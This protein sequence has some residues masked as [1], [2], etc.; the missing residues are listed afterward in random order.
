MLMNKTKQ[1]LYEAAK[2]LFAEFGYSGL[3]MRQL[4]AEAGV[5]LSVTYH[6]YQD[7]DELLRQIFEHTSRQLGVLRRKLPRH[8]TTRDMLRDRVAFQLDH[9]QDVVF[10]LKYYMHYRNRYAH[11]DNGYLPATAYRHIEEVLQFGYD[12]REIQL[13]Q[14]IEKEAKVVAHAING[15]LLEYF[16]IP[17]SGKEKEELITSIT[18]FVYRALQGGAVANDPK[19]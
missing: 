16:P 9:C 5:S 4:A 18:D 13:T 7:K 6:Y 14:P 1:T 12:I 3:S 17:P 19:A 8:Q 15:F 10:I 2:R 11:H